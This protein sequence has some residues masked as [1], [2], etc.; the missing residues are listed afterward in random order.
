[1]T[2]GGVEVITPMCSC[3]TVTI[4]FTGGELDKVQVGSE[5]LVG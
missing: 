1:M 5:T 2:R 4:C 3:F